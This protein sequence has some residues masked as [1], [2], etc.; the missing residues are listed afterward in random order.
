MSERTFKYSESS[1][2]DLV[3]MVENMSAN[4]KDLL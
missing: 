3:A 2:V 1:L 4:V